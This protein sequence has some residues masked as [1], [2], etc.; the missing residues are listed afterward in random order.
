MEHGNATCFCGWC[1]T[2]GRRT[3]S[4]LAAQQGVKSAHC[5]SSDMLAFIYYISISVYL[6]VIVSAHCLPNPPR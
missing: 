2:S 4:P 1:R 3:V 5:A 6:S